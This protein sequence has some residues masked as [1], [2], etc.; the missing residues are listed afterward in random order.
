MVWRGVVGIP[1][2]Q[3]SPSMVCCMFHGVSHEADSHYDN[4]KEGLQLGAL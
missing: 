1:C 2:T 3:S 4:E